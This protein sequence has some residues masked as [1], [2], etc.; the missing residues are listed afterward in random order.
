MSCFSVKYVRSGPVTSV[1]YGL[2][3]GSSIGEKYLFDSNGRRL[4]TL[5]GRYLIVK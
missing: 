1:R 5:S 2:I 3:C 4:M